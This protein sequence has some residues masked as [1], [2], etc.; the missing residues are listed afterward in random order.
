VAVKSHLV[1]YDSG[2]IGDLFEPEKGTEFVKVK[3]EDESKTNTCSLKSEYPVKGSIASEVAPEGSEAKVGEL[4]FPATAIKQVKAEGGGPTTIGL[5]IGSGGN[6]ANFSGKFEVE[7]ALGE[8]FGA[9]A[10]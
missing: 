1:T 5:E 8:R 2:K 7:M 9:F 6:H 4:G 10:T 3:V